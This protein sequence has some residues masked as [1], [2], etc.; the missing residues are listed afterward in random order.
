MGRSLGPR[1][2]HNQD[3]SI[4]PGR[5][6][7]ILGKGSDGGV[8]D[9]ACPGTERGAP[10]QS[11][12]TGCSEGGAAAD[13]MQARTAHRRE[14]PGGAL[15]NL[16]GVQLVHL[17]LSFSEYRLFPTPEAPIVTTAGPGGPFPRPRQMSQP[18]CLA[19]F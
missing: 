19:H 3:S 17:H 14:E 15:P 7:R 10:H 1:P 18:Q 6:R 16:S 12:S 11:G 4:G 9:L 2:E 5:R 8:C 13:L